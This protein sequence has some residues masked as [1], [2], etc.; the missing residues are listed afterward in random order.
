VHKEILDEFA[1]I[2]RNQ[3]IEPTLE[4]IPEPGIKL[5][6][7]FEGFEAEAYPDPG[8]GAEPITIG[9]GSTAA[10][11]DQPVTL[12][13]TCTKQQA[14]EWL[15]YGINKKFLPTLKRSVNVDLTQEMVDACLSFIYNVG[16]GNFAKSTM[17]KKINQQDW[18][19]AA[20]QYHRSNKAARRVL[21]GLTRRRNRER[22][23][24][25]T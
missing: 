1:R 20:D 6:K 3:K 8:T 5:I 7:E 11:I 16:G 17:L 25:L 15:V 14:E 4:G 10:A 18:C 24:F 9:Y 19:G 2:Y 23:L 13:M 22:E 21:K 12:G